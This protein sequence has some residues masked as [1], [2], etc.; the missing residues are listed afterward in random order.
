MPTRTPHASQCVTSAPTWT[1]TPSCSSD[2]RA[3]AG[4]QARARLNQDNPS[5]ARVDG[6]EIRSQRALG[7]FRDRAALRLPTRP[8][9][10]PIATS[11]AHSWADRGNPAGVVSSAAH[12]DRCG[13]ASR[14]LRHLIGVPY[15]PRVRKGA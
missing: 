7:E 13:F 8:S 14:S 1:S 9:P 4:K 12:R 3:A 5:L 15:F 11:A 2:L 10:Q 6:T